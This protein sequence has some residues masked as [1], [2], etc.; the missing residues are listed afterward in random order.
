MIPRIRPAMAGGWSRALRPG[1]TGK[2]IAALEFALVAPIFLWL[3]VFTIDFTFYLF[4][5]LL[6]SNSVA[7]GAQYAL[8]NGQLTLPNSAG[9]TA[10]TPPCLTVSGLRAN[11]QTVVQNATSLT[12]AV[13]TVYINTSSSTAGDTDSIYYSCYCPSTGIS[14]ASQ[15]AVACGTPCA[16]TTQPG[17]Y[18]AI[19]ASVPY[20]PLFSGDKWLTGGTI[21]KTAWVRIQ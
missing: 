2:G 5:A 7:A 6:L 8:I 17:S 13:P 18:I 16:D 11:I 21:S 15:T 14:P 1:R 3:M 19:Q 20:T 10:L 9:C 4:T 12:L